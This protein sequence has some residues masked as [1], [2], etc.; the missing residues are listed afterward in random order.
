[1]KKLVNILLGAFLTV[2]T[3]FSV[4]GCGE[5]EVK[6]AVTAEGYTVSYET[7]YAKPAYKVHDGNEL[8]AMWILDGWTAGSDGATIMSKTAFGNYQLAVRSDYRLRS[9]S[10]GSEKITAPAALN[11]MRGS[12]TTIAAATAGLSGMPD[13]ITSQFIYSDDAAMEIKVKKDLTLSLDI[14]KL[15]FT[16]VEKWALVGSET[17]LVTDSNPK[18]N[19]HYIGKGDTSDNDA[20]LS[21]KVTY[22]GGDGSDMESCTMFFS[23]E[24][25]KEWEFRQNLKM[26]NETTAQINPGYVAYSEL[27]DDYAVVVQRSDTD[28]FVVSSRNYV[29]WMGNLCYENELGDG[30]IE[31]SYFSPVQL[32]A[33]VLG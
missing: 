30:R 9:Y 5:K 16:D 25:N 27:T 26:K 21:H 2:L 18:E 19:E 3:V 29:F 17:R 13:I 15:N 11:A 14:A 12:G 23:S 20:L 7:L 31:M 24:I 22:V 4:A 8:I 32:K 10:I 6:A 28:E 1:M 33:K